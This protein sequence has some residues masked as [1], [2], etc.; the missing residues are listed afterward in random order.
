M[1]ERAPITVRAIQPDD[2]VAWQELYAGYGE[3]YVE[4]LTDAKADLVWG[5][6]LDSGHETNGLVAVDANGIIVG[7]GHYREFE[8][9]LAGGVGLYLDDLFTAPEA[10]GAGVGSALIAELVSLARSR[11]ANTVRWIT[12]TENH[13]A[14]RLYDRI[15]TKTS[16]LTY[17]IPI[18]TTEH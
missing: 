14:Q 6:L 10:R 4:P 3:F 7:I 1:T 13:T 8:R 9:P 18:E 16:Y 5:W 2:R 11:G 17:D 12:D 15:A